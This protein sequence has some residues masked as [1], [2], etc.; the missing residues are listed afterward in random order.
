ML[1]N[2]KQFNTTE[3]LGASYSY[4]ILLYLPIFTFDTHIWN[5]NKYEYFIDLLSNL[6]TS[7]YLLYKVNTRL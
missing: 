5:M 6:Q 3:T 1:S 7:V 2:W 4:S